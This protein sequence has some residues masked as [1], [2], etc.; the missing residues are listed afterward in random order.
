MEALDKQYADV[1]APLKENMTPKKFGL[2]YVQKLAKRSVAPY[3]VPD[4]VKFESIKISV[5]YNLSY[6]AFPSVETSIIFQLG[7][8]LNSM[9]RMLDALRPKIEYQFKSWGSCIPDGGNTAPGE[10]LSEV[11][12]ML[13]SKFR[14]Y[15]QAVV[16]KLAEN[17]SILLKFKLDI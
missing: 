16:E 14:S 7:I 11:T 3:V 8:L 9:K 15:L 4:E 6:I 5:P 1:V 2:K 13:R 12:V 17:V 10:R